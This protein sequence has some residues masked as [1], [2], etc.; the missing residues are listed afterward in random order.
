M[1]FD[2][3]RINNR[4]ISEKYPVIWGKLILLNNPE[5]K[6]GIKRKVR[7][8]LELHTYLQGNL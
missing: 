1:F 8:Y 7:K 2:N 4:K 3:S 5:V 6:E